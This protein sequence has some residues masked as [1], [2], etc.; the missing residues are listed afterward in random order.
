MTTTLNED[1]ASYILHLER[2]VKAGEIT[3]RE[4]LEKAFGLGCSRGRIDGIEIAKN[5][6]WAPK[7]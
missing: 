1:A 2:M 3:Q 4:A 6:I 7:P 5:I